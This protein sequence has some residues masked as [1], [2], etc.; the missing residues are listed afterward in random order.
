MAGCG[1]GRTLLKMIRND[2]T[3]IAKLTSRLS[4]HLSVPAE[5]ILKLGGDCVDSSDQG[6]KTKAR[7]HG[8]GLPFRKGRCVDRIFRWIGGR[9]RGSQVT[10]FLKQNVALRLDRLKMG[11][12]GDW[13]V[14]CVVR[15]S[16]G[17]FRGQSCCES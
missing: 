16:W 3:G 10:L 7:I 2:T 11:G 8:T 6:G 17:E 12:G 4:N 15:Q 5:G 1:V 9:Y 14:V 13:R